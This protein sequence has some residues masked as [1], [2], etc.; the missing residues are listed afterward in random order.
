MKGK[1]TRLDVEAIGKTDTGEVENVIP[2]SVFRRL[3]PAMFESTRKHWKSD[4][5]W[6][7]LTV[8]GSATIKEFEV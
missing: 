1:R 7:T 3:Y 6:T 4:C 2:I 5:D 8:Y